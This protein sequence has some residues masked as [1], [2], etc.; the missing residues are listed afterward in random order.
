MSPRKASTPPTAPGAAPAAVVGGVGAGGGLA[1]R[2]ETGILTAATVALP[3]LVTAGLLPAPAATVIGA[4][5]S[6]LAAAW[7]ISVP[8]VAAVKARR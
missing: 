6:G 5:I 2:V 8:A 1:R 7:H 3:S 4:I